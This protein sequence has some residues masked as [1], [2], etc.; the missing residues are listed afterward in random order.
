MVRLLHGTAH[1]ALAA[2]DDVT[3]LASRLRAAF[4]GAR[5]VLRA[6]SG[7]GVPSMY[8][9]CESIEIDYTIGIGMNPTLKNRV[10]RSSITVSS[11][12]R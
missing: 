1:A 4:P 8:T 2:D 11:S 10:I 9:A 6:D 3:Y 5:I 12:S 7:F